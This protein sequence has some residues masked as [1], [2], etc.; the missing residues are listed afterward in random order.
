[1]ATKQSGLPWASGHKCEAVACM[2]SPRGCRWLLGNAI[3]KVRICATKGKLLSRMPDVAVVVEDFHSMFGRVL[4]KGKLGGECLCQQI[5]ELKVNKAETT[6]VVDKRG[7]TLVVLL[8]EFPFQLCVKSHS[9]GLNL[10]NRDALSWFGLALLGKLGHRPKKAACALGRQNLDKPLWGLAIE[11]K[12]LELRKA[13]V[14][15]LVEL[16]HRQQP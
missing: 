11:G 4:L 2:C 10:V 14:A 16:M 6:I 13:Q 7:G 12:L 9:S 1:M 8:G 5:V 15:K 3:M